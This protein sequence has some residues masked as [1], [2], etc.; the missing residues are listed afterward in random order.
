MVKSLQQKTKSIFM[1]NNI[2]RTDRNVR[3]VLGILIAAAGFYFKS[4]WGIAAILPFVTAF[5]RFCPLYGFLGIKTSKLR[6]K[7][8]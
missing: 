3:I 6:I 7:V 2:G 4:W 1:K 5:A 8:K